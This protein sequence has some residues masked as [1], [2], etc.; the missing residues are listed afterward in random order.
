M[1]FFFS[2]TKLKQCT[3]PFL[4][5]TVQ[6][7]W[8]A[9]RQEGKQSVKCPFTHKLYLIIFLSVFL[10]VFPSCPALWNTASNSRSSEAAY[11]PKQDNTHKHTLTPT[12][13]SASDSKPDLLFSSDPAPLQAILHYRGTSMCSFTHWW[14]QLGEKFSGG[15][16]FTRHCR[17]TGEKWLQV[18][19]SFVGHLLFVQGVLAIRCL[20]IQFGAL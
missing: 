9:E 8:A 11:F 12:S 20:N 15:L 2:V 6:L 3:K 7:N 4:N 14:Q 16:V 19:Q 5:F 10:I 18:T 13:S 17:W 1:V